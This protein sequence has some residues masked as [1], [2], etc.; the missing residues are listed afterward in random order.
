[1]T[2]HIKLPIL[3][4]FINKAMHKENNHHGEKQATTAGLICRLETDNPLCE[5]ISDILWDDNISDVER[6]VRLAKAIAGACG[7]GFGINKPIDNNIFL[8]IADN[9]SASIDA[10][11][12]DLTSSAAEEEIPIHSYPEGVNPVIIGASLYYEHGAFLQR[13]IDSV[14]SPAGMNQII[15]FNERVTIHPYK[16]RHFEIR[17]KGRN[18]EMIF[19][20]QNPRAGTSESFRSLQKDTAEKTGKITG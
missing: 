4:A 19:Y 3:H 6:R 15:M 7:E 13:L 5:T 11:E 14:R 2:P 9:T 17:I 16:N 8:Q 10:E 20:R 1:M 18:L 12:N